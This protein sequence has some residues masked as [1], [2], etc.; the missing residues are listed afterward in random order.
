MCY[1]FTEILD[2]KNLKVQSVQRKWNCSEYFAMVDHNMIS[3][4]NTLTINQK[5]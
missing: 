4:S 2:I 3:A 1:K 5:T